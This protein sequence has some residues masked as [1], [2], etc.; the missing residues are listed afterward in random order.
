[1]GPW[2]SGS[3][4]LGWVPTCR[5][6]GVGMGVPRCRNREMGCLGV[7]TAEDGLR[8]L[9]MGTWFLDVGTGG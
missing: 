7:G 2:L 3:W 9:D 6:F 8:F 1:M 4:E 5:N